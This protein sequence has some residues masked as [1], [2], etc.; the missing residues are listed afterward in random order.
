MERLF[1]QTQW[2][3]TYNHE[4]ATGD[5][6]S[7]PQTWFDEREKQE[8]DVYRFFRTEGT[9]SVPDMSLWSFGNQKKSW[10]FVLTRE[11]MVAEN[12]G[13]LPFE[14]RLDHFVRVVR[15]QEEPNCSGE[16]GLLAV[17]VCDAVRKALED[18]VGL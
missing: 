14:R 13:R 5:D 12:D 18:E 15:R 16:E 8:V 2:P 4:S 3:A 17:M 6:P 11:M 9:L 1:Y 10:G 7:L